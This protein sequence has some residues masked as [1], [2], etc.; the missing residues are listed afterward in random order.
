[1]IYFD[2]FRFGI[3]FGIGIFLGE[4]ITDWSI[5]KIQ[6]FITKRKWKKK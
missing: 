4:W 1:M 3:C 6:D 5:T 2:I